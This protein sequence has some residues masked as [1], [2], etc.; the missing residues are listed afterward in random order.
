MLDIDLILEEEVVLGGAQETR[1]AIGRVDGLADR[2]DMV[3]PVEPAVHHPQ[4]EASVR[5]IVG[6][7]DTRYMIGEYESRV[8]PA[9]GEDAEAQVSRQRVEVQEV[10]LELPNLIQRP[11]TVT[12]RGSQ[13]EA[14]RHIGTERI[15]VVR[16]EARGQQ[17][18]VL[19][20]GP[21]LECRRDL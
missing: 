19:G 17:V 2:D 9:G 16:P 5:R 6:R 11:G 13:Q 18:H 12:L 15:T 20:K 21:G 3:V 8:A 1:S 4:D 7:A 14:V 10:R